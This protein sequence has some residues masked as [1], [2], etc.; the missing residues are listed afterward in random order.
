MAGGAENA[1]GPHLRYDTVWVPT[2]GRDGASLNGWWVPGTDAGTPVLLYLHGNDLHIGANVE[3]VTRLNA[4]G[5]SVLIV[6]YRGYGK[7]AGGFPS[8]ARVYEDA[9]TS[10]SYLIRVRQAK[11]ARTF[12]YSIRSARPLPSIWP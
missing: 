10:W 5:F 9:E 11:P 3:Y 2:G 4:M 12:I 8:E 6:D 7:S 1:R